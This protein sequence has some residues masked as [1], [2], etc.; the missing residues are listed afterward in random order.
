MHALRLALVVLASTCVL[1]AVAAPPPVGAFTAFPRYDSLAISPS[2]KRLAFTQRDG[3]THLLTVVEYPTMKSLKTFRFGDRID[4][5]NVQWVDDGRLLLQPERLMPELESYKFP[6]G[7]IIGVSVETGKTDLLWSFAN[8]MRAQESL[9]AKKDQSTAPARILAMQSGTAGEVLIHTLG[10]PINKVFSSV[11]RMN[12]QTG[13][14]TGMGASPVVETGRFVT[15]AGKRVALYAGAGTHNETMVYFMPEHR[16]PG[17]AE[18]I[19]QL[20]VAADEGGFIPIAWTGKGEDYY[21]LDSRGAATLGVTVWNAE[22]NTQRLLFRHPEA[23]LTSVSY[24]PSGLP[25]VFGGTDHVPVYW[26]PDPEH[27]LARMHRQLVQQLPNHY[28]DV[29][30]Q[31]DDMTVA[32][33][34]IT[35]ADR[36]PAF[37]IVDVRSAKPLQL[38]ATY[39]D[40]KAGEMAPVR[41]IEFSAR[42]GLKIRGYVTT[43]RGPDGKPGRKL[44]TVVMVHGGPFGPRDDYRY[45]FLRQL[46]AS[47]GYAVLQVNFRG[48]GGRGPV[49]ER[50]GYGK[51]GH[52]MQDDVTDG[53]RWAIQEGVADADRVCIFGGSYGAYAAL[54]G[55]FR[56]PGLF[57]CAIGEA[58]VYDLPLLFEKGDIQMFSRGVAYLKDAIGQDKEDLRSRSPVYNAKAIRAKVLLMHGAN[59][60]RA[61]LA[62][63]QRMR[64]ALTEA[65]NPP[66]WLLEKGEEHGFFNPA[67]RVEAYGKVLDFLDRNI[68]H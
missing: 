8:G 57:K 51:W 58:G 11:Y 3:E 38:M 30:S 6:T 59:D 7:E 5:E 9:A 34:Q 68:G 22:S 33:V 65:G 16:S 42:D 26:Y 55:A 56:E 20:T 12:A 39:P 24:D 36:P 37:L 63:A 15:G 60:M 23:D 48:S 53:L 54:T 62:H 17:A 44:P 31:T 29:V 46:L 14:L 18:W 35:A 61:P 10:S 21:A 49:F 41:P 45:D 2:G 43:P 47:R 64:D 28:V 4:V 32:V 66:E 1:P 67:H 25:W 27:P 52:E 40:L 50:A 19:K 13:H